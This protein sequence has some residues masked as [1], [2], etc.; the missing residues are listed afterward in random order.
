MQL[1]MLSLV[2]IASLTAS[3]DSTS[4]LLAIV[5]MFSVEAVPILATHA[6]G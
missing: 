2:Y 6:A 5:K 3:A 1:R 4:R